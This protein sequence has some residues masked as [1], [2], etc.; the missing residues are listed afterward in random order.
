MLGT[1][2]GDSLLP[3]LPFTAA[4]STSSYHSLARTFQW[5]P[6]IL[7]KT[8]EPFPLSYRTLHELFLPS[9]SATL[10]SWLAFISKAPGS[11]LLWT[12]TQ[13]HFF[14]L[15]SSSWSLSNGLTHL[16]QICYIA[17][18]SERPFLI[19]QPVQVSCYSLLEHII[20]FSFMELLMVYGYIFSSVSICL[21]HIFPTR[22]LFLQSPVY[23]PINIW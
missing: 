5:L 10:P 11:F 4:S 6:T 16:L 7:R 1:S 12:I 20:F 14:C 23:S 18:F 22:M 8:P 9:S 13:G 15:E 17:T 21:M 19:P 3:V 2:R